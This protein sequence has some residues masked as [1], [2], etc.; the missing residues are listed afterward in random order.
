MECHVTIDFNDD[1]W[2]AGQ[3][4]DEQKLRE[5]V[6][7]YAKR[8]IRGIHWLDQ[9][10]IGDGLYDRG[11]YVDRLGTAWDFIRAVPDPLRVI[12]DE[13][14]RA[15]MRVFSVIK[16][17]DLAAGMPWS[18]LPAGEAPQPPV[19]VSFI[20]GEGVW[21]HRWIR[22]HPKLRAELHPALREKLPRKPIRTIRLWHDSPGLSGSS[23]KI[24]VSEN[25]R[26]YGLYDGP[27]KI[28]IS[29]RR[30]KPPVF[31]P[32]PE[33]AYGAEG[34]YSCIEISE[35]NIAA[36]FIAIELEGAPLANSLAALAELEDIDGNAAAFTYG[37]IPVITPEN[38]APDW[39]VAGI[40][41][42]GA[43]GTTIPGR[44][45]TFT[46]SG[47]RHRFELKASGFLGLARGR[48][49]FLGGV[50]EL[51]YPQ[52]RQWLAA[53]AAR[54]ADAGCDGVDIRTTTHT[55]SL[56]WE[57]YGFGEPVIEELKRRGAD[58]AVSG[59]DRAAWRK[60]RG[61]YFEQLLN[62]VR[63]VL[64][65]KGKLLSVQLSNCF[66]TTP[67]QR[68]FHEIYFNWR[69]WC[70]ERAMDVANL[71]SF[72]FAEPFYGEAV[73]LC[74]QNNIPLMMTV[75]MFWA[76]DADWAKSGRELF[77]HC[78]RDGV[79]VF[80]IYESASVLRLGENGFEFLCPALWAMVDEFAAKAR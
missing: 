75:S 23:V 11:A 16:C 72:R 58:A 73:K 8:G 42:D 14:H 59:F 77:D 27:R 63:E 36:P 45:W 7:V 49:D 76:T 17:F 43:I 67:D 30:R 79:G 47:G 15:D 33:A 13:A 22:E 44:G 61:E 53:M 6:R 1:L 74:Q 20:G 31:T 28:S 48:N 69:K 40:A 34:L 68:C 5:L 65:R 24:R 80:N 37:L 46:E 26:A 71:S 78:E 35:L 12:A 25:N 21:G 50:V 4:W 10:G 2:C 9:G 51:A 3:A 41:F 62:E 66:D 54:A 70:T 29:D 56:D 55:E 32:A 60:L 64:H 19:G 39:R 18:V 38:R 57:N 52:T